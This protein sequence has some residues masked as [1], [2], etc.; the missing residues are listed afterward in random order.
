[1]D[2]TF[3]N[4]FTAEADFRTSLDAFFKD[5]DLQTYRYV[6]RIS[7]SDG[8]MYGKGDSIYGEVRWLNE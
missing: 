4:V 6:D 3:K 1:M 7:N 2:P 5:E 8:G